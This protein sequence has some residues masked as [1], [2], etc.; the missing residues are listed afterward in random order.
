LNVWRSFTIYVAGAGAALDSK[1]FCGCSDTL[2]MSLTILNTRRS[3]TSRLW[4]CLA[5][6]DS[7]PSSTSPEQAQ[8]RLTLTSKE[9]I[10]NRR[11]LNDLVPP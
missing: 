4:L 6:L 7:P 11:C 3:F 10:L 2:N 5:F 9:Q 8:I 1:R